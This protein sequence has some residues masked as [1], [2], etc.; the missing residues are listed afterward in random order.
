MRRFLLLF[1]SS[2]ALLQAQER[3]SH[4]ASEALRFRN[5]A[6]ELLVLPQG[7]AFVSLILNEEPTRGSP[8]WDPVRLGRERGSKEAFGPS[9]GHFLCLDGFGPVTA[10]ER[11]AGFPEHGDANK[12]PWEVV[13]STESSATFRVRLPLAR[14]TLTRTLTMAPREQVVLVESTLESE[15]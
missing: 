6:I 14:E 9:R 8:L 11:D 12:L 7:G 15:L 4:E 10:A 1:L 2:A 3:V 13:R 5:G